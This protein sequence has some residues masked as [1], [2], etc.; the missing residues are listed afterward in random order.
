MHRGDKQAVIEWIT[1]D[2]QAKGI[3]EDG[4]VHHRQATGEEIGEFISKCQH[5]LLEALQKGDI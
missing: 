3:L 4:E 1:C 2:G 5:I